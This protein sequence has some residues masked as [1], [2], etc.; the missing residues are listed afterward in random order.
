LKEKK[1]NTD[2]IIYREWE[3]KKRTKQTGEGDQNHGVAI[4]V[5]GLLNK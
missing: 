4:L 5:M 2:K 1:F 3:K